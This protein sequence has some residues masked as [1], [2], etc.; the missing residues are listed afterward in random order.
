MKT[1]N[2]LFILTAASTLFLTHAA[3]AANGT[4]NTTSTPSSWALNT[5]WTSNAIADGT[6]FTADFNTLNITADTTVNLDGARTI[7]NLIFGDTDTSS[8]AGWILANGSSGPLTLDATTPTITV[9]ALGTGKNASITATLAGSSG[10]TK[11]GAGTLALN[12]NTNTIGGPVVVSAGTLTVQSKPLTSV[13]SVALN[14]G[15]L[16]V[17]TVTGNAIGPNNDDVTI[18][19]NGGTLQYNVSA[20]TTDYSARFNTGASQQYRVN[21][22]ASNTVTFS[23]NLASAGGTLTKLSTGTLILAAAN[24]YSGATTISGG[25]LQ[26]NNALALQNSPIDTAASIVGTTSAGLVLNGVTSPTFGGLTGNK[27]LASLFDTDSGNY[28]SVT[29]VTLNPGTDADIS[30]TGVIADGA[31]SMTLTKTGAGKQ[32]L[33]AANTFTGGTFL[34]GGG[35]LNYSND[36]AL[37]S[38][39]ITYNGGAVL[40]AGVAATLANAINVNFAGIGSIG[41]NGFDTTLSGPITG[42]GTLAKTGGGVLT[43]TGGAANTITGG[44]RVGTSGGRLVVADGLSL[45]GTGPVTV[46]SGGSLDYSKNITGNDLTNNLTLSGPGDGTLGAL[47]LRGNATATG[48]ITLVADATISHDFNNATI[49]NS[50]T[51]TDRNLTL[52]T[53]TTGTPQPGMTV[54]GPI[55]LG[56]GGITVTGVANSGGFSIKLSGNNTYSGGTVVTSGILLVSNTTGSGTGSG[57]VSVNAGA[58]IGGSGT[59]AGTLSVPASA[60]LVP[61]NFNI[62]TLSVGGNTVVGGTYRCGIDGTSKDL[63][64]VT[65]D[66]DVTGGTLEVVQFGAGA[67]QSSYIIASYT[68]SL[69]GTLALFAPVSGYNLVHD[70]TNK[71]IRLDAAGG[72]PYSTWAGGALFTDD[73]NN[74]G[75]D[76]GLAWILGA[77][78]PTVSALNK[79]PTVGTPTGFLTLSFSRVNP[80][81]P[82]KLYIEYSNNLSTWTK[83]EIPVASGTIPSSNVEVVVTPGSPDAVTVKIPTS[84]ASGG[85]LFGRLSSTEN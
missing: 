33:S 85:K 74:D 62:G 18:S 66:L 68:G 72:T 52:T 45:T 29:N 39:T 5:N 8:A 65:G 19:F 67:N 15:T 42:S 50:I 13:S 61:G 12:N 27:A 56:T 38:G 17:A 24:T 53:L 6:G 48:T 78:N 51:G 37:S 76:N 44:F 60:T 75:V 84:H 32:T 55:N 26:L 4:W 25:T 70:T 9:N 47:N 43:L 21:V 79:L 34:S 1:R 54:S 30:Y 7:G 59:I 35:T 77:A 73:A 63:L 23:S 20:P 16:V 3:F 14:G 41:T 64:A 31:A 81:A 22:S 83:L 80:Y 11:A 46:L 82:A 2:N 36:A 10:F 58:A 40:Q 57:A 69:T 49:S 71:Q 28:G